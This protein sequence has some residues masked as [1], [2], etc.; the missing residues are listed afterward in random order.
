MYPVTFIELQVSLAFDVEYELGPGNLGG[1]FISSFTFYPAVSKAGFRLSKRED[2]L[3]RNWNW[4]I[5]PKGP[6]TVQEDKSLCLLDQ[7]IKSCIWSMPSEGRTFH[8]LCHKKK[9]IRSKPIHKI[10]SFINAEF[11]FT[12]RKTQQL[13]CWDLAEL[14][15]SVIALKWRWSEVKAWMDASH[16]CYLCWKWEYMVRNIHSLL[17]TQDILCA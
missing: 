5:S 7:K 3:V 16:F 8:I 2:R 11:L 17:K 10:V 1:M 4:Q 9:K 14:L 13:I 12:K 15:F 6:G